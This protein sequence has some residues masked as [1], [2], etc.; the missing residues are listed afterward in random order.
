M[1][2]TLMRNPEL[3]ASANTID[4]MINDSLLRL[5]TFRIW[6]EVPIP[7]NMVSILNVS[8][9]KESAREGSAEKFSSSQAGNN[10]KLANKN[11]RMYTGFL[12]IS[13][14]YINQA[15]IRES[16]PNINEE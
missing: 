15:Q 4:E 6:V 5:Y 9:E 13:C 11:K 12:F 7:A 2:S 14:C 3:A 8:W 1:P 16:V 10:T